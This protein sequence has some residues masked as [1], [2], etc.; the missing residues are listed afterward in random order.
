MTQ[1]GYFFSDDETVV[2]VGEYERS[3]PGSNT[4]LEIKQMSTELRIYGIYSVDL[5]DESQPSAITTV[6]VENAKFDY[7]PGSTPQPTVRRTGV[8]QDKYDILYECWGKREKDAND[9]ITTVA[10]WYSDESYYSNSD[11]R[12]NTFEK[13]GRYQ[14]SV[15]LKAKDGY[16]FDSNLSN[17]NVTLNGQAFPSGSWVNV[18]DDGQTCLITYGTE[19]R[20]GQVVEAIRLDAVINFDAGDAPRFS[21]GVGNP[22]ID[23]DHQRWDA[24]DGSGYGI[25]S[26]DFWNT[27]YNGKLITEFEAGKSYIYGVYFKISDLGMEEGYRFDKNTKL[28]INGEEITLTPEQI[29][30]GDGG[31]T[32]WFSNVLTMTPKPA[33]SWQKIDVIE[34]DGATINFKGSDKPTFTGKTPENAPYSYQFECWE[35]RTELV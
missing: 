6:D 3:T 17:N 15:R 29:D 34:I 7:Q 22:F 28:Y 9:T 27:R 14:Y 20:P 21:T 8:N 25:T 31:E 5:P 18:L 23:T 4:N 30:V 1:S 32:I 19:I 11:I 35:T 13:G 24:N 12:F 10:Y 16:I 26:S 2:F 33:K